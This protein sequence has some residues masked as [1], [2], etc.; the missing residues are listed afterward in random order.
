M[1]LKQWDGAALSDSQDCVST[2][3][4]GKM[5]DKLHPSRQAAGY[6]EYLDDQVEAFQLGTVHLS[7]C[8]YLHN[9][10]SETDTVLTDGRYA[11]VL[12]SK[13]H[14]LPEMTRI[15]S[16]RFFGSA[17]ERATGSRSSRR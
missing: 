2:F 11:S 1:E 13:R 15:D 10:Q 14:S 9:L 4:N 17:S 3:M 6:V 7:G 12:S 8:S 5:Q 16:S